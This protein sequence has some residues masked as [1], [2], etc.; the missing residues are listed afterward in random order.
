MFF[1]LKFSVFSTNAPYIAHGWSLYLPFDHETFGDPMELKLGT[2][3]LQ[4]E[5]AIHLATKH[6][7]SSDV[8]RQRVSETRQQ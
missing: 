2:A 1:S 3:E 4:G 5:N 6:H 8:L 7:K